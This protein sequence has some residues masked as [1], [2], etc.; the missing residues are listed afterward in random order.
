MTASTLLRPLAMCTLLA[1]VL[2]GCTTV[3]E[4]AGACPVAPPTQAEIIPKPPVSEVELLWQPGHW[5]WNGQTYNWR[6]GSWIP[7]DGRTNQ[8]LPGYWDRK[9]MPGPCNWVPAHWM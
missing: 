9:E 5:D 4:N 7:R 3:R 8:W 1:L 2:G 6:D